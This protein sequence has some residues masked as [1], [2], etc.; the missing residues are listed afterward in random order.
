MRKYFNSDD[1]ICESPELIDNP[2]D[3]IKNQRLQH[4]NKGVSD[5]KILVKT[6]LNLGLS[7]N[8]ITSNPNCKSA[9]YFNSK[10]IQHSKNL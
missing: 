2:F 3:E 6:L 9:Q 4:V 1:Y 8:K 7:F 5:K 10:L